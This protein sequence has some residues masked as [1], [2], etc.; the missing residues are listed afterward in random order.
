MLSCSRKKGKSV[1]ILTKC[2]ILLKNEKNYTCISCVCNVFRYII[3]NSL[4]PLR[5]KKTFIRKKYKTA[6]D[7]CLVSSLYRGLQS[8][9]RSYKSRYF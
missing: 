9:G 6:S 5:A 8:H 2:V 3:M 1:N 7:D 4:D